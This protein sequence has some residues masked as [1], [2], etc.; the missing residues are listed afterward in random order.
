MW[1][2]GASASLQCVLCQWWYRVCSSAVNTGDTDETIKQ[3]VNIDN[4]NDE[5]VEDDSND[6]EDNVL[7]LG[8]V[9]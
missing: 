1:L 6:E 7:D 9:V 4:D 2:H 3:D 8:F 5:Y